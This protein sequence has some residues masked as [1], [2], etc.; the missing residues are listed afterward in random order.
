MLEKDVGSLAGKVEFLIEHPEARTAMGLQGRRFV[1]Q[2]YD[3]TL[4][5][6]Q[7]ISIFDSLS[8]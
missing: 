6:Q 5:N 8:A 3:V 7:L 2:R 1:E 4:L